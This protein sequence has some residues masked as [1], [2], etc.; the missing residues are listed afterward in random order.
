MKTLNYE[1]ERRMPAALRAQT[2]ERNGYTCA[3]CGG[4]AGEPDEANPG[5]RTKLHIGQVQDGNHRS[6]ESL[7]DLFVLCSNCRGA[8]NIVSEPP[9][10]IWLLAQVRRATP[11]D[12]RKALAW[13][14]AKFRERD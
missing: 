9:S 4:G 10:W 6:K 2:L 3:L 7:D 11:D 14:E 8:E 1:V 5:L 13:L 12:Q